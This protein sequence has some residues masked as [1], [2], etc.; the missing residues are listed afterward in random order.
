MNSDEYKLMGLAPY[1][2]PRFVD[3]IRERLIDL[4][5]DGSFWMDMSYFNYCQ[6]LTMTSKKFDALFDGPPREVDGPITQR[7]MDMA[8]SIQ[9]VAEEVMLRCAR[10]VH[11]QTGM[12]NLCM[13]GGVA[14]NCVGNGR[15]LRE[16]PFEEVW[17]QP[18]ADDA[19]GALGV[20]LFIWH[21]LLENPRVPAPRDSQSGSLL[22]PSYSDR[23]I[24]E[25][26]DGA[27]ATYEEIAT[28]E[29]LCDTVAELIAAGNVVGWFQDRMEFG[30]RALGARSILGD[31]RDPDM[32]RVINVK[33]KF[34]EGF[35]PFAPAVMLEHAS[36]YF[37]LEEGRESPYML[38]VAPV[39][40]AR[41]RSLSS[42]EE[43]ARGLDKLQVTRSE[44][45]AVTHVDYSARVQTV[46]AERNRLFHALLSAFHRKTGCP[47]VV[48]TSFN[49]G[50]DPIVCS[51]RDAYDV[52]AENRRP[53]GPE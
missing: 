4:K 23:E 30:P 37:D 21:Q 48:N 33:V 19:G 3:L 1:G 31:P 27:G 8:A 34:R 10:T 6:G 2:E 45:P 50:W 24:R 18:A 40:E 53:G 32:Q 38:L 17:I 5:D 35:R 13:A 25:F 36:D 22:G 12:K 20:A 7:E 11:A 9:Q 41:R 42:Q 51:P 39:R 43:A 26:L 44:I 46:D 15:I 52:N 14:L 47:V 29:Q 16:G 49:L 28:D